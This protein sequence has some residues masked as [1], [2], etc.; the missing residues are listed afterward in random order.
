MALSRNNTHR[1]FAIIGAGPF[2]LAAAAKLRAAGVDH[3]VFGRAMSFWKE[4]VPQGTFLLSDPLACSLS[5]HG[6][7]VE[8]W[9]I[10]RGAVS[11]RPFPAD[12][13][14]QYCLW[15]QRNA[16][17]E[18]DER[19]V[20]GVARR[21]GKY[22]VR[23]DDGE[24]IIA[25]HVVVA[26][27]L[28][29][30]AFRPP[31]FAA[32]PAGLAFHACDLRDLTRFLGQRVAVIG[33]GQSALE[34]AALVSEQG[35]QV[36][37][38]ARANALRWRPYG[39]HAR[40]QVAE[41]KGLR[42]AVQRVAENPEVFRRLPRLIRAWLLARAMRPAADRELKP[43]LESVPLKLGCR[44]TAA[45][46]CDDGVRLRLDDGSSRT[47]DHVL[48]GTGYRIDVNALSFLAPELRSEIRQHGGYP[49]LNNA[50]E[51]SARRLH[52]AGAAAALS[53]GVDMW[54]VH[55][56]RRAAEHISQ[57]LRPSRHFWQLG[58]TPGHTPP[59]HL[60]RQANHPRPLSQP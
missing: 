6:L 18:L 8:D 57:V 7:R 40:K 26:V 33:S 50:M 3:V 9:E 28:S 31:E 46:A 32:L 35:T 11:T 39:N 42:A 51:C 47:V 41:A 25:D 20:A 56:A 24:E 54:F 19:M 1:H 30:F 52:F 15:F 29:A 21:K 27:G 53:F 43:R 2:G 59:A 22:A 58:I 13:F 34:C 16:G 5:N 38:I 49:S 12:E 10:S 60:D 36:E 4:Q 48:L 37:V 23:L 17:V 44:V 45:L 14:I 55:G